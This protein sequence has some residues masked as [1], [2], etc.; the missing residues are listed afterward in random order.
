MTTNG[1]GN[2]SF[3][4]MVPKITGEPHFTATATDPNG[5]TSE[6]SPALGELLNIST[7]EKVLTGN[8]VL[9]GGFIVTGD[10]NK[11]VLVRALGPTLIQF[12]V[13]GVLADPTLEL[14][15]STGALLTSNDNWKDSQ[16][17]PS[18]QPG[19][20][21]PMIPSR[22]FSGRSR[23]ATTL[24]SCVGRIIPPE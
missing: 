18:P 15:D 14:H 7:R 17:V 20:R 21:R 16:Q 23:P 1:S 5:N 22:P 2:V 12:G 24:P 9:I 8:S 11:P 19:K 6:F 3:T 10:V 13:T 4:K